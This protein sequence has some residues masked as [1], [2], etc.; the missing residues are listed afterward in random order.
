MAKKQPSAPV[1]EERRLGE[2]WEYPDQEFFNDG[3]D[4]Q[5][6]QALAADIK[7]NGLREKI[8]V[9]PANLADLPG[10]TILDGHQRLRALQLNGV[11]Q[12]KVV[13]RYDLAHV[14]ALTVEGVYLEF[15][16][17]FLGKPE[18]SIKLRFL[19]SKPPD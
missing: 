7:K 1:V 9:L 5:A 3:L 19:L 2:L 6:L 4:D 11:T 8:Q 13:V 12:T 14:D 15:N 18:S 10:N 17:C 16:Q